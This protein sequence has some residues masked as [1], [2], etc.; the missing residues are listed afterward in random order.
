LVVG[1]EEIQFRI[2]EK[3]LC[4][5]SPFFKSLCKSAW[6]KDHEKM[7]KLPK[8]DPELVDIMVYCKFL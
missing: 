8:D 3:I 6:L 2:H 7:I 1:E 5:N 4:E